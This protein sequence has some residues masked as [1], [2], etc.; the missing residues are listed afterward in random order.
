MNEYE[1]RNKELA[2]YFKL[3]EIKVHVSK[4]NKIFYNGLI[5]HIG[6]DFFIIDDIEDGAIMVLFS[7]LKI[8]IEKF[9]EVGGG[10]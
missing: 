1:L 7:E 9:K 4:T 10:E 2:E 8:P 6:S 3:N 5:T